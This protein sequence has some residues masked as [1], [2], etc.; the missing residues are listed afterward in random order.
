MVATA[1]EAPADAHSEIGADDAFV[2]DEVSIDGAGH[3]HVP[4]IESWVSLAIVGACAVF[5]F[6]KLHPSLIFR[7]T[8]ANGGD[9]GAHV[10][11]P[12]Y[13]RDH[14][15]GK[16]Q[17]TGWSPDWYAGFPVGQFYFPIP[18]LLVVLFD[19]LLPYNVA[20]KLV[21]ALAPAALPIAA[22]VFG[23]G[24]KA[25]RP[26]PVLFAL[27]A[28]VMLF[29]KGT[30][31]PALAGTVA[32]NQHVMGGTLAAN[33]AGEYSFTIALV[34]ALLFLGTFAYALRERRRFALTAFF[35]AMAV[36]S[37]VVIAFFVAVGTLAI[38]AVSRPLRSLRYAIAIAVVAALLSAVWTVPF[39]ARLGFTTQM[40]YEKI[41][42]Y[43]TYLHPDYLNTALA[44]AL[45]GVG[46]GFS[47]LRRSTAVVLILA[48]AFWVWF[49][50]WP[51]GHV[52]NLRF[53]PFWYLSVF[54][55]AACGVSELIRLLAGI[56]RWATTRVRARHVTAIDR[57][58]AWFVTVAM[59]VS[60]VVCLS[61]VDANNDKED[62]FLDYWAQWNYSGYESK[63]G[64]PE[65][66]SV[67]ETMARL[68]PGRAFW[69]RATDQAGGDTLDAYGGDFALMLLP[70]F[71]RG[72]IGSFE[73]L[74][75]D[76]SA[77]TPYYFLTAAHLS[78]NPASTVR[79]PQDWGVRYAAAL[80][81]FDLG[82]RQLQA[83]G[84]RYY[85]AQS[86][87]AKK[88][89]AANPRL[90]LVSEIPDLD[91]DEPKG[92]QV[93]EVEDANLVASLTNEPVVYDGSTRG[94]KWTRMADA[95]WEQPATLDQLIVAA[96]PK[97]WRRIAPRTRTAGTTE[98]THSSGEAAARAT[99]V[100]DAARLAVRPL[101][102]ASVTNVDQRDDS[103]S[104]DVSRTGVPIVVKTS[105]YPNWSVK[106]ADGP[107]RATPNVMVV[108][109]TSRH[110]ELVYEQ[111]RLDWLGLLLSAFGL[112]GLLGLA[113]WRPLP[114]GSAARWRRAVPGRPST[115]ARLPARRERSVRV[116]TVTP[117]AKL[118][119]IF[120]AYDIRGLYPSEID[121]DIARKVG[122]AFVGFTGASTLVV[123]R[124]MRPSSVPLAAAF[125][126]GATRAGADVIDVGLASTDLVYFASGSLDV[127]GAMFTASHNPGGYNGIKLCR[128]G[129][130]PIGAD[131]GLTQIKAAVADGLLERSEVA[132]QVEVRD[133]S[134]CV[135]GACAVVRG[136][137]CAREVAGRGRHGQRHGWSRRTEG[138]RRPSFRP[139]DTVRRA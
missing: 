135:R 90:S 91:R 108:V 15:L 53:L 38:M 100:D 31:D 85:M 50:R 115:M 112:V 116:A 134:G 8:T 93:Y 107:Y 137:R 44:L 109:P 68:P 41:T 119:T 69:E 37:H 73:G 128:A 123:G 120:K 29:F 105:Y 46:F 99:V 104:F 84:V 81:D 9:M 114:E 94:D 77:S 127:P 97:N 131:T 43:A 111:E 28:V 110:V 130:G 33:L 12:A 102:R 14:V 113:L 101:K 86:P 18:A 6:W 60:A 39:V 62:G 80:S 129:A 54:L 71:T 63:P 21:T 47:F 132:G 16:W 136:R 49:E 138:F 59:V 26:T 34:F 17:I 125:I 27:A 36:M 122:N 7:D 57:T 58:A 3:E 13:L 20:F 70:Y 133:L 92:W 74:Y 40:R 118:D 126:E 83:F 72:R 23:R 103:I 139:L 11:F 30:Q 88:L 56:L 121:E 25:P 42:D 82:I 4:K 78:R 45:I 75:Y 55:L 1:A 48:V 5:V 51:V 24:L 22:Y 67:N 65:F 2:D 87:E 106:G 79:I 61:V 117:D 19:L 89:A 124:D 64:Y 10:W 35:L 32:F 76:G 96:G 52:W 98:T 95:W 66:A